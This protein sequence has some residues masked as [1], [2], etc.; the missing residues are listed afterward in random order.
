MSRRRVSVRD[1]GVVD[2]HGWLHRRKEGRG[3][4]GGRWKRY[5]FVLKN[6]SLYWYKDQMAET[7]EGFINLSG[8]RI[9][10]SR[11]SW[12]KHVFTATHPLVVTVVIAANT[13]SNMNRWI[14]ELSRAAGSEC[15]SEDSN[16]DSDDSATICSQDSNSAENS[17][18]EAPSCPATSVSPSTDAP[19]GKT[20]ST[21]GSPLPEDPTKKLDVLEEET[22]D[23]LTHSGGNGEAADGKPWDEMK[24]LCRH[25]KAAHL[26]PMGLSNTKDF[27]T[28][29]IR[30]SKDD[31]VNDK[32]HLLRIL[33]S[34]LK[35]KEAE[36]MLMEQILTCPDLTA[37][38]YR[39]WKL[40][41]LI[42]MKAIGQ[43]N[44]TAGGTAEQS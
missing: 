15:Y 10:E 4:L 44:R 31:R 28:S 42:L 13:S 29:F 27:R 24:Q 38:L 40:N 19:G 18:C 20:F 26:T 3:F 8:F 16:Q 7:A 39:E 36:L 25:L 5:W 30:R 11:Q 37:L 17:V 41:N 35:A 9:Q 1:L 14:S 43:H 23:S 12:R 22:E 6:T 33:R 32:V 2:L 21:S 34:T